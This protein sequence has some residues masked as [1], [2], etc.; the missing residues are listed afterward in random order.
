MNKTKA[1]FIMIVLYA[2]P[3]I[4]YFFIIKG[5]HVLMPLFH[6]IST[7]YIIALFFSCIVT[8][9][10][11]YA[12]FFSP[13]LLPTAF[14]HSL[15]VSLICVIASFS[16]TAHPLPHKWEQGEQREEH[17]AGPRGAGF[18]EASLNEFT[19]FHW[20][21]PSHATD[22]HLHHCVGGLPLLCYLFVWHLCN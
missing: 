20:A 12:R 21:A 11:W 17:D 4:P 9:L 10:Y 19:A 16:P 7:F 18:N 6:P 22:Q 14:L 15:G 1:I 3:F 8:L 2:H 13:L 5:A